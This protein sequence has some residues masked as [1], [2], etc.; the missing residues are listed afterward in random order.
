[1]PENKE[2]KQ[3]N[4]TK[5]ETTNEENTTEQNNTE[6][7][8]ELTQNKLK[9]TEDKMKRVAATYHNE[10]RKWENELEE[11]KKYGLGNFV[12]KLSHA[13]EVLDLA[14]KNT[15][16]EDLSKNKDLNILYQGLSMSLKEVDKVFNDFNI[17]KIA[18]KI[19]D[20]FDFSLHSAIA[21][22]KRDGMEKGKVTE[23]VRD[24]LIL[25]DRVLSHAMVKVSE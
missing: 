12:K 22:E 20:N 14:F 8:L 2:T 21:T 17:K 1:M 9:E 10:K 24:G 15:K 19:G 5:N 18:P 11:H 25:N 4:E 16:Q 3:N 7:L 23:V 13:M 6:G